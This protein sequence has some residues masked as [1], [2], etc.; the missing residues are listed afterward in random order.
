MRL[1]ELLWELQLEQDFRRRMALKNASDE[2]LIA[3]IDSQMAD[4]IERD[5][6]IVLTAASKRGWTLIPPE[7]AKLSS[8]AALAG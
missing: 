3:L 6:K 4:W 5:P 1:F 7:G 2:D 8:E